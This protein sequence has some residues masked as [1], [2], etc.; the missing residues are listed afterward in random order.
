MA[1]RSRGRPLCD[2]RLHEQC[3]PYRK[4][5]EMGPTLIHDYGIIGNGRSAALVGLSGS[6]D[7]LC[8]PRFDSPSLLAALL[9]P[10]RGGHFSIAPGEP[11]T[12]RRAYAEDSNVL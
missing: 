5:A 11:F 10:V 9:D 6:I 3:L 12:A 7:W 8:W 4:G 1:R 2:S